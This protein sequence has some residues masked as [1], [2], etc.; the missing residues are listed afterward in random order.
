MGI[1]TVIGDAELAG[2]LRAWGLPAP[3]RVR[4]EP[5]G[6]VNTG[7]HLWSGGRRFFLRVSEGK[8][9]ADVAFEV[10][11]LRFLAEARFPVPSLVP[12]AD[13]GA[14]VEVAGRPALL[15]AYAAGEE[16]AARRR[17]AGALPA[18]RRAARAA[19]RPLGGIP[20]ER[21][22]PYGPRPR[23][24]VARGAPGPTVAAT[25]RSRWRSRSSRA[26][27][28]RAARS[29][30]RPAASF[31]ATRS[32]TTSSGSATGCARSSTGR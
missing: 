25:R 9:P 27:A 32:A 30:A 19:P 18:D 21:P 15:F 23:R 22:N 26:S 10:E 24:G 8:S 5:K 20:G 1:Y 7:Y 13:G 17:D 3:E 16:L 29:P 12:A 6:G 31:T 28:R 4:P 14:A 11:V 2:A